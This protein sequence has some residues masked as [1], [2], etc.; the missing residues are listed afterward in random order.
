[1]VYWRPEMRPCPVCGAADHRRL[2]RRG[3][4]A[5]HLG[6][7]VESEVVRCLRCHGVY[8]RPFLLPSGNPYE[9]LSPGEYFRGHDPQ[10]KKRAGAS[11]ARRAHGFLGR[12]GR[13]LE[14]GCGRG[15]LLRGAREEGWTVAGVEMTAWATPEP[16]LP[17]E[18]AA[19]A[20]ARS[21]E[22]HYDVIVLAAILEH[23]YEPAGAL[24]RVRDALAPG[25]LVYIDV[26][27]E[28]SL[29]ARA[30]NAYMRAR[31]R[32]WAVN[33]SPTFPPFHVVGFC[34]RS[35]RYLLAETGYTERQLELYSLSNRFVDRPG[36]LGRLERAGSAAFLTLGQAFGMGAGMI[37]W[38]TRR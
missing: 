37:C 27:N 20:D 3:G 1:M 18:I 22:R 10:S 36:L 38:A 26:P 16:G 28:C 30:G 4:T 33:L 31:G 25:G 23:V 29:W 6:S 2:G 14:I 9:G 35:L 5:H 15:E 24:R 34:P 8:P 13:L 7:G 11:L 32:D 12:K 17:I 19:L 21:L